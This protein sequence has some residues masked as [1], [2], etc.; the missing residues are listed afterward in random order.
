MGMTHE[1]LKLLKDGETIVF[2]GQRIVFEPKK[3]YVVRKTGVG[4][5]V[6]DDAG[7]GQF[8]WDGELYKL[9]EKKGGD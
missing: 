9:F 1:E 6:I 5:L 2:T 7:L 8:L 4:R 3:E